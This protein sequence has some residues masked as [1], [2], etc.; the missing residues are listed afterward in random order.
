MITSSKNTWMIISININNNTIS[1]TTENVSRN[2]PFGVGKIIDIVALNNS[3]SYGI[4][5]SPIYTSAAT[6]LTKDRIN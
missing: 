4:L 5:Y 1:F 3:N 2:F 6:I